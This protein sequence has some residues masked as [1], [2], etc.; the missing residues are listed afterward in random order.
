MAK[1]LLL[2]AA[3]LGGVLALA[4]AVVFLV[5]FESPELGKVG[6]RESERGDRRAAH[7]RQVPTE[8]DSRPGV[9]RGRRHDFSSRRDAG[10]TPRRIGFEATGCSRC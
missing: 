1:K 8:S 7:R 10:G 6:R 4:I 3:V 5:D 9:G 2:A